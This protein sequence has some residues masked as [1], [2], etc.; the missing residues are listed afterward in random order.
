MAEI[1]KE[2]LKNYVYIR[3]EVENQLERLERLKNEA[4]IPA[5]RESDGSKHQGAS[6][7]MANAI[8]RRIT[9]EEQIAA[10]MEAKI[11]EMDEIRAAIDGLQDPQE[12]EVLRMRYIDCRGYHNTSWRRV[13][14]QIY[15]DDDEAQLQSVY[16]IHGRALVHIGAVQ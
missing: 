13:A 5:V 1:T 10:D 8:I 11:A 14:M 9:Y 12:R 2:R 4:L 7:R 3:R 15:G 16:R 6:D